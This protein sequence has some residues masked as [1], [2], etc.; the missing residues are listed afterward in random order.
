MPSHPK[1]LV[2]GLD[3]AEPTLIRRW[4]DEGHLVNLGRL[5]EA[6]TTVHLRSPAEQFPDEVWPAIYTS[7]NSA[8]LGKYYYIQPQPGSTNLEVVEDRAVGAEFWITASNHGKR[9]AVVDVPKTGLGPPID[10]IQLVNWGAHATHAET[11]SNPSELLEQILARYGPYPL[12]SCDSHGLKLEEYQELRHQLLAGVTLRKRLIEDLLTSETWD[13]FFCVFSETH[14]AG[15]QFWHLLDPNHPRHDAH[16]TYGLQ[17]AMR[18]VYQAV[19]EAVGSLVE[20]AGPECVAVVFSGHGMQPQYHGRELLPKLLELWGMKGPSNVEPNPGRERQVKVGRSLV[21]TL[22]EAVPMPWQYAVK[23]ILPKKIEEALVCRFMGANKLDVDARAFY[24]P[25]ND[26]TPAIRINVK[27]RDPQG[28]V[29]EGRPYE[30]LCEFIST[31][32]RELI[33]PATNKPALHKVSRTRDLYSGRHLE[34]LPDLTAMWS[35]EA[36]I[37]ALYSPG[38]GTVVG[39]HHD[40]RS[41][42]HG[43]EGLLIVRDPAGRSIEVDEA[44]GRDLAPSILQLMGVP[45]PET[46]EGKSL[47]KAQAPTP[48]R[49]ESNSVTAQ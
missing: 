5:M 37:E 6:G 14:C 1:V 45:V 29:P 48:D 36:P 18:D 38:Y 40:L 20:A 15:H 16:N 41:G 10:G 4:C 24:V 39:G 21:R 49:A 26:L 13:L 34:V 46:M 17:T 30:E 43:A 33:N 9:C 27:G 22:K 8:E 11:A 31:R 12:H 7:T 3:A 25:N 47:V 35:G 2:I 28:L 42:G 32:L 44:S 23:K 19:D